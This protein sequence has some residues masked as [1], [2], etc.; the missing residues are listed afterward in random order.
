MAL[1]SEA[2][3]TSQEMKLPVPVSE[4]TTVEQ[5]IKIPTLVLGNEEIEPLALV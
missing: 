4:A 2:I 3:V 1:I 5:D